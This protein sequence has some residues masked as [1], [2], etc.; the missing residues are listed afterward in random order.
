MYNDSL[1]PDNLNKTTSCP[2]GELDTLWWV[3]IVSYWCVAVFTVVGNSLVIY[4]AY[5]NKN[6]GP[7]RYL[8]EAVKSLAV[9][10][11]LFGLLGTPLMTIN[12][13]LGKIE[14]LF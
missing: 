14:M 8:D 4:A 2:E 7:L 3:A 1:D 13:Y 9:A 6:T 12:A 5:G 11:L 10:D